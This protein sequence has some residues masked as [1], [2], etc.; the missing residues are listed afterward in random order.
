MRQAVVFGAGN[1]GRG[2]IGQLLCSSGYE[3][4]FVDV[5]P[6]L[7]DQLN[8]SGMYPI[9]F[10][11]DQEDHEVMVGPVR[12]VCATDGAAV[13]T[14]LGRSDLAAT[15][16]G[17]SA[18]PKIA[19]VIASG[20]QS[21][22]LEGNDAPI[23]FLLCENLMHADRMMRQWVLDAMPACREAYLDARAGFVEA[24]I[25]RMVPVAS[26]ETLLGNA[27]RVCVEPYGELPVDRCGFVGDIPDIQGMKAY[28]P[29]EFFIQ[30]KLFI[31]NMGHAI[32]AYLGALQ[33]YRFIWEAIR[34]PAVRAG[35]RGAMLESSVALAKEHQI[36]PLRLE[37]FVDDL[38]MRFS[39]RKLGDT[40]ERVGREP[41]R[42]LAPEDRLVGAFHLCMRHN[43]ECPCILRGIA[44]ALHYLGTT[45][46]DDDLDSETRSEE[47]LG[48]ICGIHPGSWA[49]SR[50]A[51]ILQ[52]L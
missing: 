30:R 44:A 2:F 19:P 31:H 52:T 36:D 8:R 40:I 28:A 33:G 23:N 4:V 15:A 16:V 24:S 51:G 38:I 50:I 35:C 46:G 42:K 22:W 41:E 5:N 26:P 21:R 37:T 13:R 20:L 34:D 10:V 45:R 1:I 32:C 17:V 43:V 48:T 3:V 39:N 12:A 49:H 14:I 25:G 27:L 47:A 6:A 29:F 7:V 18:L 11:T 9:R